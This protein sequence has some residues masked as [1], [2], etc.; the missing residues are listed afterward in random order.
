MCRVAS[1]F[2]LSTSLTSAISDPIF[3]TSLQSVSPFYIDVYSV[4]PVLT[5][6]WYLKKLI[7][8]S[9]YLHCFAPRNLHRSRRLL[10]L[11]FLLQNK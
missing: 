6:K 3:F 10:R 9:L 4:L 2:R 8:S 5:L 1:C 11:G 7:G